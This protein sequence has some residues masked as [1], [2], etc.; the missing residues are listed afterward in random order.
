MAGGSAGQILRTDGSGNVN[1]EY[2]TGLQNYLQLGNTAITL[3]Q[4][5]SNSV[6]N[7]PFDTTPEV[8]GGFVNTDGGNNALL[9][10]STAGAGYMSI[11]LD[12]SLFVGENIGT[13]PYNYDFNEPGW[14][15]AERGLLITDQSGSILFPD[16]TQQFTAYTGDID[17][18]TVNLAWAN[19]TDKP[20]IPSSL[21]DLGIS[22]GIV[23]QVLTTNG[24]GVFSFSNTFSRPFNI[25]GG[26]SSSIFNESDLAFDGGGA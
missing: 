23:G 15:V 12:G 25:D 2:A 17:I 7:G 6:W 24:N 14:V 22:D 8:V 3:D 10:Y 1:W 20:N 13:N 26:A 4:G 21:I 9:T 19:I 5:G 18:P 11:A 16:G